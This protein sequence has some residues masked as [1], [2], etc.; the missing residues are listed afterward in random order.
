MRLL[1]VLV[2]LVVAVAGCGGKSDPDSIQPPLRTTP[3]GPD[4]GKKVVDAFVAA[5]GRGDAKALWNL[6]STPT[7]QRLGPYEHFRQTTAVELS[8][9]V[10][11]FSRAPY[12]ELIS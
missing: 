1:L 2:A 9:G 6:L 3:T 11:S 5:A 7:Q 4:R 10:G 8:E 12:R